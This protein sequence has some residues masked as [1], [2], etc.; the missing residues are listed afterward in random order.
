MTAQAHMKETYYNDETE[1]TYNTFQEFLESVDKYWWYHNIGTSDSCD[2]DRYFKLVHEE[3]LESY[4]DFKRGYKTIQY[5]YEALDG[6]YW[7]IDLTNYHHGENDLDHN[8]TVWRQFNKTKRRVT[9]TE[10]KEV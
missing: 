4:L 6:S 3:V 10:W 2:D 7:G 8:T 5:I 1:E 9:I